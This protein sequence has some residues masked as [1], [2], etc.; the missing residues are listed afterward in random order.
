MNRRVR[1]RTNNSKD[2]K[3][4]KQTPILDNSVKQGEKQSIKSGEH[5]YLPSSIII[6]Y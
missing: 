1:H 2:S 5:D 4:A 6:G 3:R